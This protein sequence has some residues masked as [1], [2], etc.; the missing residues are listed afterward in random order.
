MQLGG[1][2]ESGMN[3]LQLTGVICSWFNPSKVA[4]LQYET[5]WKA[6]QAL[7]RIKNLDSNQ[8]IG[9]KLDV[10]YQP[11]R[12][13]QVG[14]PDLNTNEAGLRRFLPSPQPIKVT[15]GPQ[16]YMFTAKQLEERAIT[17]LRSHGNSRRR[18]Y[19]QSPKGAK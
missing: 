2:T 15:W 16:S 4:Y 3:R 1:E 6:K 17:Q 13:L 8:L 19:P 9:R 7:E 14:N 5:D 12:S 10:T 18:V 11:V